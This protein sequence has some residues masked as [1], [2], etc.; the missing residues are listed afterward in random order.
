VKSNHRAAKSLFAQILEAS[1]FNLVPRQ[2][3]MIVKFD[4]VTQIGLETKLVLQF[5][6]DDFDAVFLA[7]LKLDFELDP[8]DVPQFVHDK[9][10][11]ETKHSI[12]QKI[13]WQAKRM[14]GVCG[15]SWFVAMVVV[16][17]AD[18][19]GG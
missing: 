3:A 9:S 17:C 6:L 14:V 15:R 1:C 19:L 16:T 13:G 4:P 2:A 5:G 11:Y 7:W 8:V 12:F 10:A 18:V